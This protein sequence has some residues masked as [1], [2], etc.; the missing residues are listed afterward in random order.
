M[1][2]YALEFAKRLLEKDS[3]GHDYHH[4]LRVTR[5]ALRIAQTESGADPELVGLIAA[6]HDVDDRK[7]SPETCKKQD[8]ARYFLEN[9][10]LE[11]GKIAMILKGIRQISFKGTDSVAPDTL[12]ARCVQDADRLDA[13]GAIG[14]GRAFAFG[15]ARGRSMYDPEQPPVMGMDGETYAKTQGPT[16]NH[17]YEKLL[18]LKDMMNTETGKAMAAH[19]HGFMEAFL[20]E[21]YGEWEGVI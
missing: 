13:I 15:G 2:N 3:T 6:L 14:I 11:T 8:N 19:R 4:I 18:L 20:E 12:E 9:A 7:L 17:F 10:G 21:F 16:I 5:L 1:V